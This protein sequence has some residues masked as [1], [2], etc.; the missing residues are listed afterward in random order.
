MRV[1]LFVVAVWLPLLGRSQMPLQVVAKVIEKEIT[2]TESQPI[3]LNAQKADV[4]VKGWNRPVVSVK[5][6]LLAKHTDRAVAE[7][8]VAYHQYSLQAQNGTID[9]SNRF[10]IPQRGGRLQSQLKAIYEVSIPTKAQLTL[11]NSFGDLQLTA[12]S[13]DMTITFEFG[14]LVLTDIGGK[15]T[16]NSK[17]GDIDGHNLSALLTVRTEK[18]N[19]VLRDLE[20]DVWLKPNYGKLTVVPNPTISRLQIE[21]TWTE[22]LVDVKRLADFRFDVFTLSPNALRVPEALNGQLKRSGSKQTLLYQPGSRKPAI[23]IHE[24][25]GT[26]IIQGETPLVDR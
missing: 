4:L 26:V 20:G 5:L 8:E 23:Q 7:R 12:L 15:C 9:L 13:G 11:N 10:L 6:R 3:V 24:R 17:Y 1:L 14:K 21:A 16:I 18:A 25:Y 22:I 19:V 2:Y